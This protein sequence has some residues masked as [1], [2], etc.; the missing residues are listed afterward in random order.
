[1]PLID[2]KYGGECPLGRFEVDFAAGGGCYTRDPVEA[3]LYC[4]FYKNN[5]PGVFD[6]AFGCQ[7]PRDLTPEKYEELRKIYSS[8]RG[9]LSR[10][11]FQK[12]VRENFKSV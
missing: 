5:S 11:G 9:H 7:C 6:P 3:C 4:N 8:K 10:S 12:F 2:T 1:M